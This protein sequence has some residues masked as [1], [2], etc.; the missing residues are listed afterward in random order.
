M[1]II[2]FA[3]A[4]AADG[5]I[6]EQGYYASLADALADAGEHSTE[7]ADSDLGG[8]A[9]TVNVYRSGKCEVVMLKDISLAGNLEITDADLILNINGKI[10]EL[11]GNTLSVCGGRVMINGM[12]GSIRNKSDGDTAYGI[13]VEANTE[14]HFFASRLNISASALSTAIGV[15]CTGNAEAE[16]R[17]TDC[18][19][20]AIRTGTDK[21]EMVAAF[22]TNP[23][24]SINLKIRG[25]EYRADSRYCLINPET[26]ASS[27]VAIRIQQKGGIMQL[28]GVSAIGVHSGISTIAN[29][30]LRDSYCAS[31]THGGMY[32]GGTLIAENTVFEN[33]DYSGECKDPEQIARLPRLG[34][35]YNGSAAGCAEAYLDNC[36]F[37]NGEASYGLVVST[38]YGYKS[39]SVYLSNTTVKDL[40][41]DGERADNKGS[42]ATA[43]IGA[44]V[45]YNLKSSGGIVDTEDY[46][47]VSFGYKWARWRSDIL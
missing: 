46:R 21:E 47:R 29:M 33:I 31:P 23:D 6:V 7:S 10:L 34:A 16:I 41:V 45:T 12:G 14:T 2:L 5:E 3:L 15:A 26:Q 36:K 20:S 44:N 18:N 32:N 40:R 38:N 42:V 17:L 30:I 39:P 37:I 43:Y 22:F 24:T 11:C 27:T 1:I 4:L 25:G 13:K 28:D 9:A 8:A 19:V 35:M